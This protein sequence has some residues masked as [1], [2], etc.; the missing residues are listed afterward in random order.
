MGVIVYILHAIL[1]LFLVC[2]AIWISA[3]VLIISFAFGWP[4]WIIAGILLFISRVK[5]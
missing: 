3:A 4:I 5:K 1:A 2:L